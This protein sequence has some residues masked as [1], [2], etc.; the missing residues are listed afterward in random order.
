MNGIRHFLEGEGQA[1]DFL[2]GL[3]DAKLGTEMA[4]EKKLAEDGKPLAMRWFNEALVRDC[5]KH[6]NGVWDTAFTKDL[7]RGHICNVGGK[8]LPFRDLTT[9]RNLVAQFVTKDDSA[10]YEGLRDPKAKAKADF[11]MALFGQDTVKAADVGIAA[12]LDPNLKTSK[13][14]VMSG[15]TNTYTYNVGF[16]GEG[17]LVLDMDVQHNDVPAIA[18]TDTYR[19]MQ[20]GPGSSIN[21][22]MHLEI[23]ADEFDRMTS[24]DYG[25]VTDE[26]LRDIGE[27]QVD[28]AA[29]SATGA[30]ASSFKL[31]LSK[32][33]CQIQFTADLKPQV[34]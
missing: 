2:R 7:A 34:D 3:F 14:M 12:G 4:P 22:K 26:M 10:T 17:K 11:I 29:T 27:G 13:F 8:Q 21:V 9:A 16:T 1:A 5:K 20:L 15:G 33:D 23:D 30:T 6:S 24:Q 31:D 18:D 19:A 32:V 28:D 25:Q